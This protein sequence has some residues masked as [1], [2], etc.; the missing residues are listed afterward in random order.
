MRK[1]ALTLALVSVTACCFAQTVPPD[2]PAQ[3]SGSIDQQIEMV[4]QNFNDVQ[5]KAEKKLAREKAAKLAAQRKLE[6]QKAAAQKKLQAQREAAR[7]KAEARAEKLERR[8]DEAAELDLEMKRLEVKKAQS[9]ARLE[10]AVDNEMINRV[11][12]VVDAKLKN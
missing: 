12:E 10:E 4:R 11:K 1:I 9:K 5:S 6:A 3:V 8:A 2:Y 7:K